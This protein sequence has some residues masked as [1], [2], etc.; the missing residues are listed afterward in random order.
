MNHILSDLTVAI[1]NDICRDIWI[2]K[3]FAYALHIFPIHSIASFQLYRLILFAWS[4]NTF[5]N[6]S[7]SSNRITRE[8]KKNG[9]EEDVRRKSINK[10][11][12]ILI[13]R[14]ERWSQFD[15]LGHCFND[16]GTFAAYASNWTNTSVAE[17]NFIDTNWFVNVKNIAAAMTLTRHF[18]AP[19]F[20]YHEFDLIGNSLLPFGVFIELLIEHILFFK[21]RFM[22]DNFTCSIIHAYGCTVDEVEHC[23]QHS[24]FSLVWREREKERWKQFLCISSP[25][26]YA[27]MKWTELYSYMFR[28]IIDAYIKLLAPVHD[29]P[30]EGNA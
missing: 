11:K 20:Q 30:F 13:E 19:R 26:Q 24:S 21:C 15:M 9:K 27:I 10:S 6:L 4:F 2:S 14:K 17:L 25:T 3:G 29:L 8:E 22:N 16:K 5:Y 28:C 23:Q 7:L 18:R 1:P 12:L